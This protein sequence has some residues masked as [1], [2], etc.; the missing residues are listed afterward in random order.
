MDTL[1][2]LL[3]AFK[4]N[5]AKTVAGMVKDLV[6]EHFPLGC[7]FAQGLTIG[8]GVGGMAKYACA[9]LHLKAVSGG[10]GSRLI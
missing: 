2:K 9:H 7:G 8:E 1:F 4:L 10:K 6:R 3:P 5:G